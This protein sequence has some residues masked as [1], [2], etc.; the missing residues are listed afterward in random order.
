[1]ASGKEESGVAEVEEA[2]NAIL[3]EQFNINVNLT[4]LPFGSYADQ[5]TLM[6]S[7]GEGIDLIAVHMVPYASCATSGQ[8]YPMDDLIEEYG[9]GIIEELG[10][11]MI[12][13][14]RV[15]GELY[16]LTQGRDLCGFAGLCIPC[17]SRRGARSRHGV[18]Q[19]AR[20]SRGCS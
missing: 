19:D 9:Q 20:G 12:N 10:W 16:G 14:G 15:D 11:D 5:T 17:R 2:M 18:R 13:C 7:S 6:L 4:F 1:M 3:E 8:L